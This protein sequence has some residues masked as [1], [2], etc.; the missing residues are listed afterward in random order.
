MKALKRFG[1]FKV[2]EEIATMTSI[3]TDD[4]IGFTKSTKG[5]KSDIF[6]ISDRGRDERE[7]KNYFL[8]N[9]KEF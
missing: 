7:H 5:T 2:L 3:L 9:C 8:S 4:E 6:E 1:D